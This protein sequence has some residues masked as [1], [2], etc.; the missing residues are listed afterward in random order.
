MYSVLNPELFPPS[1]ARGHPRCNRHSHSHPATRRSSG[2]RPDNSPNAGDLSVA[3][4]K[5][6]VLLWTSMRPPYMYHGDTESQRLLE[7]EFLCVL[8]DSVANSLTLQPSSSPT[9]T[10]R[11]ARHDGVMPILNTTTLH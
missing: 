1:S 4:P 6:H 7:V 5:T 10:L 3:L 8:R 11:L 9:P 2:S